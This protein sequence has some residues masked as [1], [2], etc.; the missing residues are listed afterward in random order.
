MDCPYESLSHAM[1][2]AA[3]VNCPSDGTR[4]RPPWFAMSVGVIMDT[5][6]NRNRAH[7][8]HKERPTEESRQN[9]R[10][11]RRIVTTAKAAAKVKS[12]S[13]KL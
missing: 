7:L 6:K 3:R 9:L 11:S 8:E 2:E 12:K 13:M 1:E 5:I 4:K 10:Q